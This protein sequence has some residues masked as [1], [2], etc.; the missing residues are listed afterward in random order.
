MPRSDHLYSDT[1]LQRAGPRADSVTLSEALTADECNHIMAHRNRSTYDRYYMPD[2]VDRDVVAINLGGPS[3]DDLVQVV[4]R[5][6]RD[7]LAPIA[8]TN[9]QKFQVA[10]DP[11]VLEA[12]EKRKFCKEKIKRLGFPTAIA[13]SPD[14]INDMGFPEDIVAKE[15]LWYERYT[16]Q[17]RWINNLKRGLED[18]LLEQTIDEFH[19]TVDMIEINNQLRGIT[20]SEILTPSAIEYELDEREIAAELFFEDIDNLDVSEVFELRV[21]LVHALIGLCKRQESPRRYKM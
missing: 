5:L 19:K 2:F 14:R 9:A 3:R 7:E 20:P 17:Q 1:S 15:A 10:N 16:D 13:A 21:K 4:G 6:A 8:L 18:K 11:Q 12:C